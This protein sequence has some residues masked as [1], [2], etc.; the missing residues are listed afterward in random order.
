MCI[1]VALLTNMSCVIM[2]KAGHLVNVMSFGA[3]SQYAFGVAGFW[4]L[5][6]IVVLNGIG[7][8]VSYLIIIASGLTQLM[9]SYLHDCPEWLMDR[10]AVLTVVSCVLILPMLAGRDI[11]KLSK[12]SVVGIVFLATIIGLVVYRSFINPF[13]AG[14]ERAP[15]EYKF[16]GSQ[17]F[18]ATAIISFAFVSNQ[19]S[20]LNHQ[21]LRHGTMRNWTV[22]MSAATTL[23]LLISLALALCGYVAFGDLIQANILES[24]PPADDYINFAKLILSV[25]M[26][27]T[28]PMAFFPCRD[29]LNKM[30]TAGV[31]STRQHVL[32]TLATFFCTVGIALLVTDLG[33]VYELVGGVCSVMLAYFIPGCAIFA[34]YRNRRKSHYRQL[35]DDDGDDVSQR[36]ENVKTRLSFVPEIAG[37][38]MVVVGVYVFVT[39]IGSTV[40]RMAASE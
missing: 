16:F 27:I 20:F 19:V 38:V 31:P 11:G 1:L 2:V 24:F 12:V 8:L 6:C 23:A 40:I 17:I 35:Q 28:Y 29:S 5:N 39:A 15:V 10:H 9:H 36:S 32:V 18:S 37:A 25:G 3:L 7:T 13:D 33:V 34:V 30:L 4:L 14:Q 21:S 26:I 22:A